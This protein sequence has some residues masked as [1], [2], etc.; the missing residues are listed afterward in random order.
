MFYLNRRY[1]IV[2]YNRYI[3]IHRIIVTR[4]EKEYN[5]QY[6]IRINK[7]RYTIFITITNH[8]WRNRPK[9]L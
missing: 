7:S 8:F 3:M 1:V 4:T 2:S 6:V 9:R 5:I